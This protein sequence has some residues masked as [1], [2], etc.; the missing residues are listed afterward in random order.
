MLRQHVYGKLITQK[1]EVSLDKGVLALDGRRGL[2]LIHA[3]LR[4]LIR[5]W[6]TADLGQ[7]ARQ[8]VGRR[9]GSVM[10]EATSRSPFEPLTPAARLGFCPLRSSPLHLR[11]LCFQESQLPGGRRMWQCRGQPD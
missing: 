4:R 1:G 10:P 7:A 2:S 3:V 8:A 9:G 11:D 5:G 6:S